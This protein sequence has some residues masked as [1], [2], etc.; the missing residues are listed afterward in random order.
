[1]NGYLEVCGGYVILKAKSRAVRKKTNMRVT[2]PEESI[3]VVTTIPLPESIIGNHYF[4]VVVYDYSH[5]SWS[6]FTNTKSQPTKK[7]TRFF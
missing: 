5:Y 1:M 3:F 6:L 4:V 2:N 7:M